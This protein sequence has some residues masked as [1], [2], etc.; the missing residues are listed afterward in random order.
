MS[1]PHSKFKARLLY[2]VK[3]SLRPRDQNKQT[4]EIL[5]IFMFSCSTLEIEHRTLHM[6]VKHFSVW[7]TLTLCCPK[8]L[9]FGIICY[10]TKLKQYKY[11]QWIQKFFFI[12]QTVPKQRK[13]GTVFQLTLD[14][15]KP[16]WQT[17]IGYIRNII[18]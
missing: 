18:S 11:K 6:L 13:R 4:Y 1:E 15:Q 16:P 12:A 9:N 10:T 2:I 7:H 17:T 5:A 8:L 3:L 14:S